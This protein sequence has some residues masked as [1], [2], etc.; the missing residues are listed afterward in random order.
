[1]AKTVYDLVVI[2]GGINGAAIAN[3][4]S[5]RRLK[6]ALVEKG[7][8][9]GGA[10]SKTSKLIHG[11][12]RYLES[13]RFSLVCEALRERHFLLHHVPYLVKPVRFVIPVYQGDKRPLWMMR[14]GTFLYDLLAGR[15]GIQRHRALSAHEVAI[16]EPGLRRE[17]LKGGVLYYDAQMDDARLCLENV[18]AAAEQGADC[19]NYVKVVSFL[20]ENGKLAGV[21]VRDVLKPSGGFFEIRAK[22]FV[23]AAGPWTNHILNLDVPGTPERVRTTRGSHIVYPG[24]LS[25]NALLIP[26]TRDKRIFFVIPW[27]ETDSLIGTTETDFTGNPDDVRP[28]APDIDYLTSEARRIFPK[29]DFKKEDLAVTFAGLR[30]LVKQKGDASKAN[31]EHCIFETSSGM[32][33]VT[34]GKYTTFRVV[35]EECVNSLMMPDRYPEFRLYG[36]GPVPGTAEE[37]AVEYDLLDPDVIRHLMGKYGVRYRD[38]LEFTRQ[39][40]ALKSRICPH[41]PWIKAQLVYSE[42]VEMAG[43]ADDI[44]YRRLGAGYSACHMQ[45]CREVLLKAV[46]EFCFK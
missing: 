36:S 34:G 45:K 1:M 38:V 19:A 17:G 30:P 37:A 42:L 12:I 11:G 14:L 23:C 29:L 32:T 26:C 7:D 35:A 9:A 15:S 31:R 28:E 39:E 20:K 21:R 22:K 10:S 46:E 27:Q 33:V 6:V 4:A 18:L 40:P 43:T 5:S 8:F 41:Q 13:F 25:N 2:G 44:V 24:K 16:L 3:I